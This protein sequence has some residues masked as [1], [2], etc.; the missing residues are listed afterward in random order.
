MRKNNTKKPHL[1]VRVSIRLTEQI[2]QQLSQRHTNVSKKT[3]MQNA[4]IKYQKQRGEKKEVVDPVKCIKR[5][6]KYKCRI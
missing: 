6:I 4:T 2:K 3:I 5:N 1:Q